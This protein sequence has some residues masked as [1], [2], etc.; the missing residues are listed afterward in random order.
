MFRYVT[1]N[2]PFVWSI[3]SKDMIELT[4][5]I[6]DAIDDC[7]LSMN[8]FA[9]KMTAKKRFDAGISVDMGDRQKI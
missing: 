7:S 9:A 1:Y 8:L 3:V 6:G 5:W 4:W 2:N